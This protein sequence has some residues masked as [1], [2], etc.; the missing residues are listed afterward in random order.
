MSQA[1][2][3]RVGLI[4]IT[5][6]R[7]LLLFDMHHIVSDGMTLNL[8][9]SDWLRLYEGQTLSPLKL[10]YKDYACWQQGL[11]VQGALQ[12]QE[13][14]W[15]EQ[16]SGELPLLDLPIDLARPSVRS[17]EGD[18]VCFTLDKTLT[19]QLTKLAKEAGATL[20]MVLLAAYS[21]FLSRISGQEEMLVGSPIAGRPHAD[22]EPIAGMFVNTLVLRTRPAGRLTFAD[23]IEQVKQTALA[24]FEHQDYPFE[25][26]VE[27]VATIRDVS[28]NPL[29]DAMFV[30]QNME[31]QQLQ[32]AG[33]RLSET[34]YT[35]QV[36]KFDL[37]LT[38]TQRQRGA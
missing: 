22:L 19:E 13:A 34:T 30:L 3:M 4:T 36:S 29:F 17:Y 16:L 37:T 27:K 7:H 6:D 9:I 38:V 23:Y 35:H 2:L 5:E 12:K 26:I 15:L 28:R 24:A 8:L 32:T 25:L 11:V 18:S 1:P 31:M 21:A 14:Y 20:Y 10:Q 33:I